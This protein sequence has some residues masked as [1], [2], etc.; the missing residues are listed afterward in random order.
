LPIF[1]PDGRSAVIYGYLPAASA[2]QH[3]VVGQ[4]DYQAGLDHLAH[5]VLNSRAG[6]LVD[7]VEDL[8]QRLSHRL[9]HAPAGQ[10]LSHPV[11]EGNPT[12]R[13]G[14]DHCIPDAR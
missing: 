10:H 11:Q 6:V 1:L 13:T 5:R 8:L 7:N 14:C 3:R 12:V 2:E 4:P 9:G